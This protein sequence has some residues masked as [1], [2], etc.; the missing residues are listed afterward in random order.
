MVFRIL[1]SAGRTSK[2]IAASA[3]LLFTAACDELPQV[4]NPLATLGIGGGSKTAQVALLVPKGSSTAGVR[5]IAQNA[6]NAARMAIADA[7]ENVSIELK[8]YDTQGTEAQSVAVATQAVAEGAD[9][10]IGPLFADNAVAVGRAVAPAGINVLT[11]S[12]N[13]RVAGGNVYV[14]GNTFEN[15]A[16]R[17]VSFAASQGKKRALVVHANDTAEQQAKAAVEAALAR[18]GIS[19]ASEG[20]DLNQQSL[21]AAVNRAA[22]R[23]SANGIDVV[24]L[25]SSPAGGLPFLAQLL[26][27]A[28]VNPSTVQYAGTT[29]WDAAPQGFALPGIQ[30]GWFALPNQARDAAFRNRYSSTYGQ[31]PHQLAS[32][33]FDGVAAVAA[34]LAAGGRQPLSGAGLTRSRGF[35]GATGPFRWD[36]NGRITRSLAIATIRGNQVVVID[37][38]PAGFGGFGS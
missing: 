17:L 35:E 38:A 28:G 37:A 2:A 25:T 10:I 8:V 11:L 32:L 34:S 6:E 18:A 12:N 15:T 30:G 13:T 16:N 33:A 29:R 5:T 36:A 23:S 7:G 31:A 14:L 26:P 22:G 3:V 19:A 20:F 21:Q 4:E 9:I 24:I 1:S 27:E